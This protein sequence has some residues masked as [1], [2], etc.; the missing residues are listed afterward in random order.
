MMFNLICY[1]LLDPSAYHLSLT[2]QLQVKL[3]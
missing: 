1:T 2:A 3:S